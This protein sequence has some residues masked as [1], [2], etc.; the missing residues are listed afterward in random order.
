MFGVGVAVGMDTKG[1]AGVGVTGAPVGT[2][3]VAEAAVEPGA[4]TVADD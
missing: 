4:A 3:V 2:G 1:G